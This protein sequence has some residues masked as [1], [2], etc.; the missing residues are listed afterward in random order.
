[1]GL[2]D[3]NDTKKSIADYRG[4]WLILYLYPK[5]DTPGCTLEAKSFR[6]HISEFE[7]RGIEIVGL[8]IDPTEKHRKFIEKYSLPFTLLSDSEKGLVEKIGAYGE[9]KFMGK[10]YLGVFR[11]SYLIDDSGVVRKFYG[12]VKPSEHALEVLRDFDELNS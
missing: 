12:K 10:T 2:P 8:S 4:K 11:Y 5:D 3:Q 7:R 6:D 1:M 9:K